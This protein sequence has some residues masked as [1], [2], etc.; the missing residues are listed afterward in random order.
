[1]HDLIQL[2]SDPL[3]TA[4]AIAFVTDAAAGAIDVFL[5]TT[6]SDR[7]AAG[8]DLI[9]LD[10]DAYAA[11]AIEQMRDIAQRA[12][13]QWPVLKVAILHRTGR[14]AV[15]QPSVLIA[16]STPHRADSFAACR[17]VI[18]TLKAEVTIWKQEV[19]DGAAPTWVHPSA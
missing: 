17:F 7:N 4:A 15:G 14:V 3:D 10:Y 18:D 11:M 12:R 16:V 6:R 2:S 19:W 13:Q 8:Q 1:M 9:A 5:G